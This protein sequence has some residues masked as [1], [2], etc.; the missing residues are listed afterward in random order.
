MGVSPESQSH[1][2]EG[3]C[4]A[5]KQESDQFRPGC[6][7]SGRRGTVIY[8]NIYIYVPG[9][10]MEES[11]SWE[12]WSHRTAEPRKAAEPGDGGIRCG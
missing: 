11:T 8:S 3:E 2:A 4:C 9:Y 6:I 10:Q 1:F 7:G 12:P 5:P